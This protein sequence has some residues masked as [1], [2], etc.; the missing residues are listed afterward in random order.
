MAASPPES[1]DAFANRADGRWQGFVFHV[2][3]GRRPEGIA[4]CG[5]SFFT[6]FG[7]SVLS[8]KRTITRRTRCHEILPSNGEFFISVNNL[9][10]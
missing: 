4:P 6:G 9:G 10:P 2:A 3:F 8:E 5:S 7:V 1:V